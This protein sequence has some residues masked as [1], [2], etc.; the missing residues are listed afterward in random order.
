MVFKSTLF[1]FSSDRTTTT[2]AT[3]HDQI[4]DAPRAMQGDDDHPPREVD[5][6]GDGPGRWRDIDYLLLR[7]GR[8][9]GPGF[10]PGEDVKTLLHDHVKLLVVGAGGLG[11][12]LLKDLGLSGF[13]DIHVID[14]DTIDVSNLNRQFLFRDQDVGKSK[15]ICAAEAIERRISGCK[16]TPHHCRIEDKPD[17]WYQQFHVLVMG[18]DSIEAR[19]Y[20]NA[21]ACGFLEFDENDEV[22]RETIKPMVDGGTE[23]RRPKK[24]V[25]RRSKRPFVSR[26]SFL[27]TRRSVPSFSRKHRAGFQ[28]PR[29]GHIPRDHAVLRVHA[30]VVP[31]PEGV[32]AVHHRGDAAV[33]RALRGVRAADSVGEGAAERN[34]RRGRSRARRVGVRARENSRGGARDR[35]RDV[36]SHSGRRQEYHSGHSEHQRDRRRGVRVRCVLYTGPHTT[37]LA[38]WTPILKDFPRRFSPPTPRFQS[39]SSTPFN[40]N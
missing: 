29:E 37:A 31:T 4:H 34:L 5:H 14:M 26:G 36:P 22:I 19:S 6:R 10:E 20:L 21:V 7:P 24:T 40:F 27:L 15:A 17:E 12:E 30:V 32:P 23:V 25:S 13:K 39:P 8:F 33:R 2:R 11:C 28:R 9:A 18:L 3:S 1:S 38:R 35:G 16:V